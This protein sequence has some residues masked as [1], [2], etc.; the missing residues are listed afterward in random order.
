MTE[1]RNPNRDL[2]TSRH[3]P[4]AFK[5]LSSLHKL[6]TEAAAEADIDPK[7]VEL[8][9][10]RASQLNGCAYCLDMHSHDAREL[11]ETERRLHVLPAWRETEL[12]TEQERAALALTEAM[13][14][15]SETRDVPDDV[16]DAAAKVFTERQLTVVTWAIAVINTFNRFGVTGRTPLPELR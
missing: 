1:H 10:I 3:W 12:F 7:L 15:L 13:T 5:H 11:G 8:V 14:R 2:A 6:V 16:Y 4:E 9:K